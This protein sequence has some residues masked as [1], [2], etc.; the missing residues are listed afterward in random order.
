ME[1]EALILEK[2]RRV[3][4]YVQVSLAAY[5]SGPIGGCY[6]LSQNCKALGKEQLAKKVLIWGIVSSLILMGLLLFIPVALVEKL[7][8]TILPIAYTA[9]I[10]AYMQQTQKGPI[11]ELM[12]SGVKKGSYPKLFL[13]ILGFLVI[14]APLMFLFGFLAYVMAV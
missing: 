3:W 12:E 8:K 1:S 5:L 4:T 7:P 11:K 10:S 6:L 14:Q 13:T 9:V 2:P